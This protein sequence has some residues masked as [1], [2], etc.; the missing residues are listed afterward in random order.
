MVGGADRPGAA[1]GRGGVLV[2]ADRR[3][4]TRQPGVPRAAFAR[5]HSAASGPRQGGDRCERGFRR[6]S[7]DRG[8]AG[9]CDGSTS[10]PCAVILDY[11]GRLDR[12]GGYGGLSGLG[13]ALRVPCLRHARSWGCNTRLI[14]SSVA[15]AGGV[16]SADSC[17]RAGDG[18]LCQQGVPFDRFGRLMAGKLGTGGPG[19]AD[20][21]SHRLAAG[22]R[23]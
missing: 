12:A 15:L 22:G 4:A 2:G 6:V 16:E 19:I 7:T 13:G 11:H 5:R 10:S 1:A 23:I 20:S 14:Q 9:V 3:S 21:G 18:G 17:V 8:V